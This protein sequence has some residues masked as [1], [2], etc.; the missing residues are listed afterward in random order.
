MVVVG[1]QWSSWSSG[2][3]GHRRDVVVVVVITGIGFALVIPILSTLIPSCCH[4][5]VVV[6]IVVVSVVVVSLSLSCP[7]CCVH[8]CPFVG[9]W[10]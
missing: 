2:S 9:W 3:G 4:A 6:S 5:L 7:H 1:V 8:G 10:W